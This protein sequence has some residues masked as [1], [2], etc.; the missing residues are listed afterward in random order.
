MIVVVKT[1]NKKS[2][3]TC[4]SFMGVKKGNLKI[5]AHMKTFHKMRSIVN[6]AL[7]LRFTPNVINVG[8]EPHLCVISRGTRKKCIR[9]EPF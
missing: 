1:L 7:K 8:I 5:I 4:I 3:L 9:F 6:A 2:D